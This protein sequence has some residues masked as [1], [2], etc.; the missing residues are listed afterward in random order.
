[1]STDAATQIAVLPGTTIA[2]VLASATPTLP[3]LEACVLLG[4]VLGL[5]RVQLITRDGQ[6]LDAQQAARVE[7]ILRRRVAGEPVAYLTGEREFF[8]LML[9]VGPGVLIPR[10]DTELL[11]ELALERL[12]ANGTV[13]DLG[14]GSGAIALA[15]ATN[16]RDAAVLALDV[17]EAALEIARRNTQRLQVDVQFFQSDWYGA[18]AGRRFD[19][20]V[21]NP[22]YIVAGDPHLSQG[23]LRYEPIDALT[24]H[25]DGLSAYRILIDGAS[26]HLKTGGWLLMEHG[27]DQSA[28]VCSLLARAGFDQVQSWNDLAGIARVSGGRL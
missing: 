3:A 2:A 16:R 20:L 12:P 5:S 14:T 9:E 13:L 15:L 26:A 7:D 17:S 19:M 8:G 28:A 10:P 6:A 22:P 25:D 1:M 24:D 21:S 11:V 4:H 18:V 23:D 27:Y